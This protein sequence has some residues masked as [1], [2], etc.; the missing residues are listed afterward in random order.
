MGKLVWD[1]SIHQ[2]VVCNSEDLEI[3]LKSTKGKALH[4]TAVVAY[5]GLRQSS[6]RIIHTPFGY[7]QFPIHS[8]IYKTGYTLYGLYNV[9]FVI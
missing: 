5:P 9:I 1:K 4:S 8:C 3:T 6:E 2:R 7:I